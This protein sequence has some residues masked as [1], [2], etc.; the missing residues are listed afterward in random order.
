MNFV[1]GRVVRRHEQELEARRSKE[2]RQEEKPRRRLERSAHVGM[3]T[4]RLEL[5]DSLPEG[6][7]PTSVGSGGGQRAV[8]PW[9]VGGLSRPGPELN[10]RGRYP[11]TV[12]VLL[13]QM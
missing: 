9:R 4:G 6:V 7:Q 10:T 1:I 3:H 8:T 13:L 5:Y 11:G 2:R 12:A